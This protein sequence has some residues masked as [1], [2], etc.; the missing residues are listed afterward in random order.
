VPGSF[1]NIIGSGELRLPGNFV[2]VLTDYANANKIGG[3]GVPGMSNLA[4]DT[5]KNP[6]FTTAYVLIPEPSTF[7]LLAF[8]GLGL[9]LR[10]L[11]RRG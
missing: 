1:L 8:A 7:G 2:G 5:I 10:R 3:L 11:G 4:I 9:A 6:G